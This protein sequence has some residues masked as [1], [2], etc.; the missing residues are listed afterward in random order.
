MV[1]HNRAFQWL[2]EKCGFTAQLPG[3][4]L[5]NLMILFQVECE[6]VWLVNLP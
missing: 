4:T 3:V 6:K 2:T 5:H 1:N